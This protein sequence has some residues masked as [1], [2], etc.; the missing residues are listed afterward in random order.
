MYKNHNSRLHNI[1]VIALCYTYF[2]CP[3]HTINI[4]RD[5]NLQPFLNKHLFGEHPLVLPI[6]LFSAKEGW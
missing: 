5:I 6:P 3:E 1:G 2:F 4:I